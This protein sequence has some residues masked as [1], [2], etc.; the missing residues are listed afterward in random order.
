MK[1]ASDRFVPVGG[2]FAKILRMGL[3]IEASLLYVALEIAVTV[4]P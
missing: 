2:Q 4:Q 1:P 3:K